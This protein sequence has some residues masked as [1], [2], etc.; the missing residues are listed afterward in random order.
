M[1]TDPGFASN[2]INHT[3]ETAQQLLREG[4]VA[5]AERAFLD[6]LAT[7][8][9]QVE[10][11]RFLAKAAMARGDIGAAIE[12]LN[13]T[14]AIDRN[15][16]GVLMELGVAYRIADRFDASRYVFERAL[17]LSEGRNTTA[18]LLLANVLELDERP[19]LAL[20]QYFRAILDAQRTGHW[21]D[22][23]STQ[24]GIRLLVQHA[25]QY[26]FEGR[27]AWFNGVLERFREEMP[28]AELGRID[29]ALAIYLHD[30]NE[31]P[32]D[33]RQRPTMLYVPDLDAAPIIGLSRFDWLAACTT[34][35]ATTSTEIDTCLALH[36]KP[37]VS[38]F[39]L[40]MVKDDEAVDS[41]SVL[42]R[43]RRIAIYHHGIPLEG[44]RQQAPQLLA[45][46]VNMPLVRI[47]QHSPDAEIIA[48]GPAM[49]ASTPFGRS[50]SRCGIVIA[51]PG[52]APIDITIGGELHGLQEGEALVFD[53]SFG[54]EYSNGGDSE[55]RLLASE[56]WHPDLT[57]FE[58]EALTA[59]TIA[60]VDFDTKLEQA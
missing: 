49:Q 16:I 11:L 59:L 18:R 58:R 43:V 15:D 34:C 19:E 41:E 13:R 24:E 20:I 52:S 60:I 3:L 36:D 47:P 33:P 32:A 23:N 17:E 8:P 4:R 25:M 27:Q 56:I 7:Q 44:I 53:S 38:A 2:S 31:R 55:A 9:E 54:V 14:A 40:G 21:L 46:M 50:N 12:W 28:S 57:P 35:I 51:L 42:S 37:S 1:L 29:R 5:E 48:I 30:S 39:N 45:A 26:V 22:D 10:A 6:V